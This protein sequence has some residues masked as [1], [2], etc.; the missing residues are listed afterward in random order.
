MRGF[1]STRSVRSPALARSA[2]A[3][4]PAIPEPMPTTSRCSISCRYYCDKRTATMPP[5]VIV[6]E[7]GAARLRGGNPWVWAADLLRVPDTDDD[8]VRVLDAQSRFLGTA[9]YA[10]RT[11]MPLRLLSRQ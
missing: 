5:S 6:S 2:A 4:D 1:F 7:R 9:L 10:A 11:P 8:V 3:T